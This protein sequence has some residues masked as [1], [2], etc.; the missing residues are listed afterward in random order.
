MKNTFLWRTFIVWF[1]H[2]VVTY[3]EIYPEIYIFW[4]II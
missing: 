3:L 4:I 1:I 2:Y